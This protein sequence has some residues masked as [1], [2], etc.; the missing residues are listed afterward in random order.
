MKELYSLAFKISSS[1]KSDIHHS[2]TDNT[3]VCFPGG[4]MYNVQW[5]PDHR[6]CLDMGTLTE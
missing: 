1:Y 4:E 5:K 2:T 3:I 6:F